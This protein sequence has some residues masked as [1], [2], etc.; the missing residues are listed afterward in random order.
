[1]KRVLQTLLT[2]LAAVIVVGTVASAA[3][4]LQAHFGGDVPLE[5]ATG[6]TGPTS[7]SGPSGA[8]GPSA[9]ASVSGAT[10]PTGATGITGPTRAT[11]PTEATESDEVAASDSPDFSA[12]EGLTGLDNAICRH[13]AL[14]LIHPD[15]PGL[16]HSLD[17][18]LENRDAHAGGSTQDDGPGRSDEAHGNAGG[19]GHGNAGGNGDDVADDD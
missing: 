5:S 13:E 17:R 19:N 11:G 14:L 8:A 10:G 16:Q 9:A 7:A 6:T 4:S 2:A 12:C 18:L 3:P 1:M 15:N